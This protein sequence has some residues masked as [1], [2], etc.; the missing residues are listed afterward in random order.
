MTRVPKRIASFTRVNLLSKLTGTVAVLTTFDTEA[1]ARKVARSLVRDR[2]AA[3]GTI[4]PAAHSIY[5]W[6]RKVVEAKESVL[7]LKTTDLAQRAL[8]TRLMKL[9]PYEAPE[10]LVWSVRSDDPD[11]SD[12]LAGWISGR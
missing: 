2:L 8:T 7:L 6:K 11:Y 4:F 12:W 9:H 5:G 1:K 3:C 10:I